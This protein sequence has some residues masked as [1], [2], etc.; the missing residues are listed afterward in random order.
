M[1]KPSPAGS[2]PGVSNNRFASWSCTPET[3]ALSAARTLATRPEWQRAHG[4]QLRARLLCHLDSSEWTYRY[5]STTA[6]GLIFTEPDEL[7]SQVESRLA[8]EAD[9]HVASVLV[10]VMA[11][12]LHS[13][14]SDV[15]D[16]LAR[17]AS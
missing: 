16:I 3:E 1:P 14:P 11:R 7:L 12:Y 8:A 5:L 2:Q 13:R 4:N 9:P 6:I 15:D 17:L 10:H